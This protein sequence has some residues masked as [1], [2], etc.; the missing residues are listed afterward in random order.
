MRNLFF[1]CKNTNALT[2]IICVMYVVCV[3]VCV[4]YLKLSSSLS[5]EMTEFSNL[6]SNAVVLWSLMANAR[7]LHGY[8][9]G[10]EGEGVC[11][12]SEWNGVNSRNVFR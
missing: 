5:L 12:R 9:C 10:C 3:C 8:K 7:T 1:F 11:E 4:C 6:I 2:I